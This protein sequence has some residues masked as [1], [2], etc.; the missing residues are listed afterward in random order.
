M[1]NRVI[2]WIFTE[3]TNQTR[4]LKFKTD[5]SVITLSISLVFERIFLPMCLHSRKDRPKQNS[6]KI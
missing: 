3:K 4:T 2:G 6:K 1:T 5:W